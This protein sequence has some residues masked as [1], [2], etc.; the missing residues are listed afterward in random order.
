MPESGIVSH[1]YRLPGMQYVS[2]PNQPFIDHNE[3]TDDLKTYT[4]IR[5]NVADKYEELPNRYSVKNKIN[6][7]EEIGV[8]NLDDYN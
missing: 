7:G 6:S 5:Q 3:P 8:N 2:Q 4:R 1:N